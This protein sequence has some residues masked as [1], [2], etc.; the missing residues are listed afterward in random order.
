VKIEDGPL[1]TGVE[2]YKEFWWAQV[3]LASEG[4]NFDGNGNYVRFQP[5]GGSQTLSTGTVAGRPSDS[6]QLFGNALLAPI[7]TRPKYPGRRSPYRPDFPCHRNQP[8]NLNG[9]AANIGPPDRS[10]GGAPAR[11]S[12]RGGGR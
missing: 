12:Q 5:G 11:R 10:A 6:G 7:G 3:G 9:P 1:S 4:Q 2:N 8:P